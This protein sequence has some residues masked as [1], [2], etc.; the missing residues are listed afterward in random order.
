MPIGTEVIF[1]QPQNFPFLPEIEIQQLNIKVELGYLNIQPRNSFVQN[2]INQAV[3]NPFHPSPGGSQGESFVNNSNLKSYK[4]ANLKTVVNGVIPSHMETTGA[5]Y[6]TFI[7]GSITAQSDHP[8]YDMII[9][10]ET[11]TG[12]Q[13]QSKANFSIN[14]PLIQQNFYGQVD[15]VSVR[16]FNK[17]GI[18][19][20]P[21]TTK[22]SDA[23]A[24]LK[25]DDLINVGTTYNIWK[26]D[27]INKE[28][29]N[30]V[31][32]LG[33]VPKSG[34]QSK[35]LQPYA[36]TWPFTDAS[37]IQVYASNS[38]VSLT[39]KYPI[40]KDY[41]H[42]ENAKY[43]IFNADD[44]STLQ[45]KDVGLSNPA[46][47]GFSIVFNSISV[48][49]TNPIGS[50]D[51]TVLTEPRM[52]ISWGSLNDPN[53]YTDKNKISLYT[54]EI[55]PNR[56]PRIYFNVN[57]QEIINKNIDPNHNFVELNNLKQILSAQ[58]NSGAKTPNDYK[59]FVYYSGP[60]LYIGNDQDPSTWQTVKSQTLQVKNGEQFNSIEMAHFLD[61]SANINIFAQ[62]M[63]FTYMYGP[64]L[65][66]PHDDQNLPGLTYDKD[67]SANTYN[68][69][70]GQNMVADGDV[71]PSESDIN[72]FI[73]SNQARTFESVNSNNFM[74]GASSYI[75]SRAVNPKFSCTVQTP[76]ISG[77]S[78][79]FD[80]NKVV[81]YKL[82]LPQDLGGHVYSKFFAQ[83]KFKEPKI[84]ASY[85]TYLTDQF[86]DGTVESILTQAVSSNESFSISQSVDKN[87]LTSLTSKLN[88]VFNNLNRS[89]SGNKIL[90]FMRQ[91]VA[92][93]KVSAGYGKDLHT[94]FEGMI[95]DIDIKEK[96]DIT[97]ISVKADDLMFKLFKD[98]STCIV[99]RNRMV[100][101]GMY[102][103]DIINSIVELTE[104]NNH[105]K[106]DLSDNLYNYIS[107]T[108]IP[109]KADTI[110]KI[111]LAS[112][113]VS[114]YSGEENYLKVIDTIC[115]LSVQNN[116]PTT[117]IKNFDIPIL[118]WY[119]GDD[120]DGVVMSSRKQPKDKDKF[121]MRKSTIT[122]ELIE[123]ISN[124]HGYM[125]LDNPFSSNSNT[126]NLQAVGLYR[127]TDIDGAFKSVY[128]KN[129][130]AFSIS[131]SPIDTVGYVGYN[132]ILI[133]DNP[134]ADPGPNIFLNSSL[135]SD[136]KMARDFVNRWMQAVYENVYENIEISSIVTKPLKSHGYFVICVESDD[137]EIPEQYLYDSV[138]Y[139]FDLN[140]NI[141]I[142]NVS[143]AKKAIANF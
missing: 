35:N 129:P 56:P 102:Y 20:I 104:L 7:E 81:K 6:S 59:I 26:I 83:N 54:L 50:S 93:I 115:G 44:S 24:Q 88:I 39:R 73:T 63:N 1:D 86:E 5:P 89:D 30:L 131:S 98:T 36:Q 72:N 138:T 132:R 8:Y 109:R 29:F 135:M 25:N 80:Y 117:K 90:Q 52:I 82:T 34:T 140:S 65:F 62:F 123:N 12:Y 74:G 53:K 76:A 116:D 2:F 121:Y 27:N 18:P 139:T 32:F 99:S 96:L 40:S 120:V 33:Y 142:A 22:T 45:V 125:L 107:K 112:L 78:L 11:E 13:F 17:L 77:N 46:S 31:E 51:N 114:P 55:S 64:P 134:N 4:S 38:Q 57:S 124:L 19:F 95:S 101:P 15:T 130:I 10:P 126:E 111:D 3:N 84:S 49:N 71:I 37:Q 9:A 136:E 127:F 94:Y 103:K 28:Q 141:I 47:V 119:A 42:N 91:N 67:G 61:E 14:Q 92:V 69:V 21:S 70:K 113:T 97:S 66:S 60:Y 108:N 79:E 68:L 118:Y 23:I 43:I 137:I 106:Y 100:F 48:S 87:S 128:V 58:R 16:Q 110:L 143:G 105:F 75:D 41:A 122:Q 133:F 85:V